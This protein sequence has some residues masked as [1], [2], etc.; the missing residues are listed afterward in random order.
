MEL[1][2]YLSFT[3]FSGFFY[4]D[5]L[6]II[7][8]SQFLNALLLLRHLDFGSFGKGGSFE[9]TISYETTI[10]WTTAYIAKSVE[11]TANWTYAYA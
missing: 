10:I 1:C 2:F 8:H 7:S 6:I 5:R 3:K 9:F 11:P 4:S